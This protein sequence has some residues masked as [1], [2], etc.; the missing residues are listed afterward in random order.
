MEINFSQNDL[1][2]NY[3][4]FDSLTKLEKLELRHNNIV[5]MMVINFLN[6]P[7]LKHLDLSDTFVMIV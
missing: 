2:Y 4:M 6:F 7:E 1:S 3:S 5:S